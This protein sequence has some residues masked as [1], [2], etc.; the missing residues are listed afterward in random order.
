[1]RSDFWPAEPSG[2]ADC[3][4]I[5]RNLQNLVKVL[6]CFPPCISSMKILPMEHP[7]N[8]ASEAMPA[9]LSADPAPLV[10][11]GGV[12]T[13]RQSIEAVYRSDHERLWKSLLAFT[14]DPEIASDAEAETF[15][16]ALARGNELQDPAAWVWRSAFR[17]ATGMMGQR[18][19]ASGDSVPDAVNLDAPLVELLSMLE[20]LTDQQRA[21]VVLR[22]AAGLRPSEIADMLDTSPSVVSVQLH[23]SHG[24]LRKKL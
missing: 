1:M 15:S 7:Q 2:Q 16:Q 14:G 23:R 12:L 13:S 5:E 6:G 19:R 21:I 8:P 4:F 24:H 17:I 11:D 9:P 18:N 10:G 20:T 3:G 22:Y